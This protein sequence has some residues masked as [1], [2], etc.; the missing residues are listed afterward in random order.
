MLEGSRSASPFFS[1][2]IGH[3]LAARMRQM[4]RITMK[5]KITTARVIKTLETATLSCSR[6]LMLE[7]R[8]CQTG[9]LPLAG[10]SLASGS[11]CKVLFA[12]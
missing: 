8:I 7:I 5:M 9:Y 3:F 12:V 1:M 6:D 10:T 2:I 4:M 11:L